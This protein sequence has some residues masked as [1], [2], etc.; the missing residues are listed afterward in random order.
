MSVWL[1]P[2]KATAQQNCEA[3]WYEGRGRIDVLI[4]VKDSGPTYT[5]SISK[6][7]LASYLQRASQAEGE[8][9]G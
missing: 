8:T 4:R 7:A 3:W 1:R 5:C 6:R 9:N 2:R